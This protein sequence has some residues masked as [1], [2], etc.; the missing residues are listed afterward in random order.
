MELLKELG[1]FIQ[2]PYALTAFAVF[3]NFI[4][5]RT[6]EKE[7]DEKDALYEKYVE[8]LLQQTGKYHEF[9][10]A[11]DRYVTAVR[12]GGKSLGPRTRGD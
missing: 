3:V 1:S 8:T 11:L 12:S 9:A 5:W 4:L 2:L 7:R 6:L 10:H